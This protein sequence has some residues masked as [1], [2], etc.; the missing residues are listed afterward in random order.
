MIELFFLSGFIF[1]LIVV[2]I[3]LCFYYLH[4]LEKFKNNKNLTWNDIHYRFKIEAGENEALFVIFLF[5]IFSSWFFEM[6]IIFVAL[7]FGII[8]ICRFAFKSLIWFVM[9]R[10]K[11]DVKEYKIFMREN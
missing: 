5:A 8:W 4:I 9:R 6:A 7:C 1:N 3:L 11:F 10:L 2:S